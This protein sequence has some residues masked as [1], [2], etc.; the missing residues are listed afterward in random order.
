MFRLV[1]SHGIRKRH[2]RTGW[3]CLAGVV[4]ALAIA[5]APGAFGNGL[6]RA[7]ATEAAD[8]EALQKQYDG[9]F[10]EV[11]RDPGNLDKTFRFAELAVKV[12]NFEAAISALERMLLVNP[13]LPRVRLELGVLYFRLGSYQLAQSYLKRAIEGEVP[14]DVR[15]R[16]D[17]YLKEIAKRSS[18]HQF[19]GSIM[20]GLRYQSNANAGPTSNAIIANG[21][22][23]VLGDQFTEQ[24]DANAFITGSVR[25]TYDLQTQGGAL[26]ESSAVVYTAEQKDEKQLDLVFLALQSGPRLKFPGQRLATATYRPYVLGNLVRLDDLPYQR[27]LGAGLSLA[28]Q[29]SPRLSGEAKAQYLDRWYSNAGTRTTATGRD[30]PESSYEVSGRYVLMQNL[31]LNGTAA[32]SRESAA[33]DFNSN[34]EFALTLGATAVYKVPVEMAMNPSLSWTTGLSG[35]RV[36]TDY[37][38]ADASVEENQARYDKEWRLTLVQSVPLTPEWNVVLTLQRITVDSNLPNFEYVNSV[39]SLGAAWRF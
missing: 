32:Y 11:F 8:L 9:A 24:S 31:M 39:A 22:P 4:I 13:N 3:G 7:Q 15:T 21:V 20:A 36:L 12:G 5:A 33:S 30:G 37:D 25:H 23:A 14:D 29:F 38:S 34:R 2:A 35:A 19:S 18:R 27:A 6:A 1:T 28:N 17:V 26:I 16:V 10:Q